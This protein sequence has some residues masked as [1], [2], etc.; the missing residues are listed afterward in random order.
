MCIQWLYYIVFYK[1]LKMIFHM[2]VA[3]VAQLVPKE[4]IRRLLSIILYSGMTT[5]TL[6]QVLRVPIV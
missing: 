3:S 2:I 4:I 6:S 1:L 5:L